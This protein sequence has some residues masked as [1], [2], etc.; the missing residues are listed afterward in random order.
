MTSIIT[1][2][3]VG[4]MNHFLRLEMSA[5]ETYLRCAERLKRERLRSR[6]MEVL[7]SHQRRV[8]FLRAWVQRQGGS[9]A[10]HASAWRGFL[11]LLEGGA[12]ILGENAAV[13]SLEEGEAALL[14]EYK[15]QLRELEDQARRVVEQQLLPE[16]L[17]GRG[18]LE[19][20]KQDL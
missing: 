6:I 5:V 11:K 18:L 9:P 19:L 20:G 12:G 3:S 16:E 1:E 15:L 8:D 10:E 2:R 7:L 17:R 13:A 14:S 4:Q